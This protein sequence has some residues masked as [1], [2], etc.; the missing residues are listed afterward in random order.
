MIDEIKSYVDLELAA[1][2]N[3]DSYP[4]PYDIIAGI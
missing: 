4:D 1:I 2:N 3:S